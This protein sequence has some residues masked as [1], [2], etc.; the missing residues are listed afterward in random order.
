MHWTLPYSEVQL[1]ATLVRAGLVLVVLAAV[2]ARL[3]GRT[4]FWIA[5]MVVGASVPAAVGARVAVDTATDPTSHNLW[6]FEIVLG[7]MVGLGA[8][9][10]GALLAGA[11]SRVA[12]KG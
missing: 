11:W 7:A 2:L 8:A 9:A 5:T 12:E 6:P 4:S 10:V 1:P 3:K